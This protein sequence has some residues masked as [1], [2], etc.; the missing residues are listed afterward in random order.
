MSENGADSSAETCYNRAFVCNRTLQLLE[1]ELR[2]GPVDRKPG[3]VTVHLRTTL[4]GACRQ[5]RIYLRGSL[6]RVK[7]RSGYQTTT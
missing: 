7:R 3:R 6:C 2:K 5:H 1:L 4:S